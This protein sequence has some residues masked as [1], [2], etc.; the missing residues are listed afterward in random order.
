MTSLASEWEAMDHRKKQVIQELETTKRRLTNLA[1][2]PDI[3]LVLN[4]KTALKQGLERTATL[5]RDCKQEQSSLYHLIEK[6]LL[7][8]YDATAKKELLDLL[9]SL[10]AGYTLLESTD[11]PKEILSQ[12]RRI[13]WE[14]EAPIEE[15]VRVI[16]EEASEKAIL[17]C[18]L[19]GTMQLLREQIA[20]ITQFYRNTQKELG[21]CT[22]DLERSRDAIRL[23]MLQWATADE[24][25][26]AWALE[27]APEYRTVLSSPEHGQSFTP[28]EDKSRKKTRPLTPCKPEESTPKI[29]PQTTWHFL[30]TFDMGKEGDELPMERETFMNVLRDLLKHQKYGELDSGIVYEK[31]MNIT[32]MTTQQRQE[33]NKVIV[34]G[35]VGWKILRLGGN[36]RLFLMIDEKKHQIRFLPC[37][38]KASYKQH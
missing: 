29:P 34:T 22:G 21:T 8:L 10:H 28:R 37:R 14:F 9:D 12:T 27:H 20:T 3:A 33:L 24:E 4:N 13:I 11:A 25:H 18:T 16:R 23:K 7:V 32:R 26:R 1:Q 19:S 31:L 15:L 5:L 17:Q 2:E 6:R 35:P 38:R 36:H 30:V